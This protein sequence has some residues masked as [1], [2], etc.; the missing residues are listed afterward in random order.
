MRCHIFVCATG[1]MPPTSEYPPPD[2]AWVAKVGALLRDNGNEHGES[3]I[4]LYL[5]W[6]YRLY[7]R[8]GTDRDVLDPEW[9]VDPPTVLRSLGDVKTASQ[10]A[11]A[12]AVLNLLLALTL[13]QPYERRIAEIYRSWMV[14]YTELTGET[15]TNNVQ[16]RRVQ[17]LPSDLT[18]ARLQFW[19]Q[20][21]EA[22]IASWSA[23][24]EDAGQQR[25]LQQHLY[26]ALMVGNPD[27]PPIRAEYEN[28]PI[29]RGNQLAPGPN[30][31]RVPGDLRRNGTWELVLGQ[32]KTS[33]EYGEHRRI[34]PEPLREV[35][36]RSLRL[37]P[38]SYV[39]SLARDGD[40][41]LG[42]LGNLAYNI[43][44]EGPPLGASTLRTLFVRDYA[45][46]QSKRSQLWIAQQMMHDIKTA[47]AVYR[48]GGQNQK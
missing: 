3:T 8:T 26:V 21:K 35:L 11:Y 43:L 37:F 17:S 47:F 38:R 28:L 12:K 14:L 36:R 2:P 6:L 32:Y 19:L 34:V 4:Q 25:L 30:Y 7:R 10:A 18:L 44:P 22:E 13:Q 1:K 31:L 48:G 39:L 23:P 16:H 46:H 42:D 33:R 29:V 5:R 9:L 24:L 40:K 45:A 15:R 27:F 20:D 41:P